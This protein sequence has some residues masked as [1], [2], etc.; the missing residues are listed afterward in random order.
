ML[1]SKASIVLGLVFVIIGGISVWLAL[2][3]SAR[4]K[5][6]T[7]NAPLI[8]AHRVG[9]YLFLTLFCVM[10]YFMMA[11][12]GDATAD[13]SP[14]TTIHLTLAMLLA[15]L[16]FVKVLVA[17]YYKTYYSLLMPIGVVIFVLSFVLVAVASGPYLTRAT[18]MQRV[19]LESANVPPATIDLN[20]AAATMQKRCSKC[21]NLDRVFAAR[22][23]AEGWR[24]TVER[25]RTQ[26]D[27]GIS[28]L[29]AR[30]IASYL[31]SQM[32]RR[33]SA[34]DGNLEVGRALVDQRCSRCHNLDRIYGTART[35]QEWRSIV[36]RMVS[37]AAGSSGELQSGEDQQ[38][39]AYLSATQTPDAVN[40]RKARA[41]A[42]SSAGQSLIA[43]TTAASDHRAPPH[44]YNLK[45]VTFISVLCISMLVLLVRRPGTRPVAAAKHETV[46][47]EIETAA[48]PGLATIPS[49]S[50][51]LILR[52]ARITPQTPDSKTLRF[53]LS[54]SRKLGARPGQFLTFS[55]LFDGKRITRSYS[56]CSSTARS[57][58]VEITPKRVPQGC[59]SLFLNDR[60]S[61]G[62]TVEANGP[63]GR[64]CFDESRQE[65]VVLL[66]AGSGVTPMMAILG[67]I[68]DLCLET[69]VV[70]LYSVRT[71]DDIMFQK[72]LEG[73]RSSIKN[74]RYHVLLSQP[75][76][77]WSG[78][79]GRIG[80]EFIESTV[81]DLKSQEY[82]LCGPPSFME[83]S[84]SALISLGVK[85]E[86]IRQESFGATSVPTQEGSVIHESGALVE[87]VRSGQK[88][89]VRRGQTLLQI[90]EEHG[91]VI[92]SSCRQGQCG[93]CRTKLLGGSVRMD[94]EEGLDPDSKAHGFVLTC[95]AHA[96]G[97]VKLDA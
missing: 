37:Y 17:R 64:F 63:F 15:P 8:A 40:Q 77:D 60:V 32:T 24:K 70:L 94:V 73:F 88:C 66:A 54:D 34:S 97:V 82:F 9:G 86:R 80:H 83:A 26:P 50:G 96:Q 14:G 27:S 12:L 25:M 19:S 92:P 79:R 78:P 91:V 1:T 20:V 29:D 13:A 65:K 72:Q 90:A 31:A 30:M 35:S 62:M 45:T 85:P 6:R 51:P 87:F 53:V 67:Y 36:T 95:V 89:P 22:K 61:L 84:R 21:H 55:L 2:H 49:P 42:A 76:A 4:L 69:K 7:A 47:A 28:E 18:R 56:I 93:T 33:R 16:L 48:E 59:A 44:E 57:G 11:R 75:D 52:L 23:D 43:Q 71:R 39:I 58:Y 81:D 5:S 46:E 41:A 74:F 38:I 3:S 68:D 10:T